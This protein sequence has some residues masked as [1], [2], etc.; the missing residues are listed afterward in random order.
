MFVLLPWMF[1]LSWQQTPKIAFMRGWVFGFG[2]FFHGVFWINYSLHEHGSAPLFLS[3]L[4]I[5]LLSA[6]LALFP[7]LAFYLSRRFK[8]H[9]AA[10]QLI[11]YLPAWLVLLEWL[12]GY[13]LTGFP[14]LQ[15][16]YALVDTPL[17]GYAPVIGG[18][19][20]TGILAVIAGA[21]S[22]ALLYKKWVAPLVMILLLVVVG[23]LL[24]D[25]DWSHPEGKPVKISMIQGNIPQSDKWKYEMHEPTMAM[26]AQLTQQHWDSDLIIWPETAIPDFA[27]RVPFFLR[28]LKT[29]AE[30][31]DTDVVF[32]VFVQGE[33]KR[34]Y[35]NAMVSIRD[36]V[37]KKRHLVPLGEF[38]P[39][40]GI[41]D[42]FRRWIKIPMSDVAEG[43][44]QQPLITGA[45]KKLGMNICFEDSFDRDIIRD[46]PEA[47]I[48]VNVS[49]DAWFEDSDEP[50][51]HHQ[52]A[53]MR[54]LEAGR[55]LLR[56]TNT[57]V[58][59]VIGPKGE[60]LAMSPQ[61]KRDVLTYE[62]YGMRGETPYAI[63]KNYL[64]IS[65]CLML[66]GGLWY[67]QQRMH[68][69]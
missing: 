19:G 2:W 8:L 69:S 68:K 26:Y 43:P 36:G 53:R 42:V 47:D 27:H 7:A 56:S 46:L 41:L 39:M 15:P 55:Y 65:V 5:A 24:Q 16:G 3:V 38:I 64:L 62:V 29:K 28:Q 52:I 9:S 34:N 51:Q 12:R 35:Y 18:L 32:G 10:L 49:N 40:R 67:Q 44:Q 22:Y 60:V 50:W 4:M 23:L 13:F 33:N 21:I 54:A 61:F 48:L 6:Y 45:G 37:Y 14:W 20:V 31:H 63:W 17:A 11:I 30:L 57:G 59:A 25:I 66:L 58:S 1:L